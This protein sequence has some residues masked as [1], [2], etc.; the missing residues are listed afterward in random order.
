M[1]FRYI[2]VCFMNI[3]AI[4]FYS[5]S[6]CLWWDFSSHISF[7]FLLFAFLCS[8]LLIHIHFY[9]ILFI[10]IDYSQSAK[11]ENLFLC[12]CSFLFICCKCSG[13]LCVPVIQ[14]TV[15]AINWFSRP[16]LESESHLSDVDIH[17]K[18]HFQ[19]Q[20][21]IIDWYTSVKS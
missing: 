2:H 19:M 20:I 5:L 15:E 11:C 4:S 12:M 10:P 16:G 21:I 17:V 6:F 1:D 13:A 3:F 14:L 18:S 9:F 8:F 7:I